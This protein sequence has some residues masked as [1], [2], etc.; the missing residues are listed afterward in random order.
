MLAAGDENF[1][2][3][4]YALYFAP[5][6]GSAWDR[7]G[8]AWLARDSALT[9]VPRRYGFHA[10]LKAPFRLAD[11]RCLAELTAQLDR[12]CATRTAFELPRMQVRRLGDFLAVVPAA[13]D[14]RVSA[15]AADC[16]Q[17]FDRFRAPLDSQE[18]AKRR[19][20]PLTARQEANLQL[21]G[22]PYVLEDF[23][24]H[25]SLTGPLDHA[26]RDAALR[27][28]R[29]AARAIARLGAEPFRFDAVTVFAEDGPGAALRAVH[30]SA[31]RRR[32]RLIYLVGPSGAGKDSLL[33]W[34]GERLPPG[35][36]V[37]FARRVITRPP[38]AGGEQHVPASV[39]EFASYVAEGAF[40]MH[41]KANGDRYGIERGIVD[42]LDAGLTVLVNGS[43]AYLPK[44]RIAFPALEVV[45]VTAAP[46]LRKARLAGRRRERPAAIRRR[47]A[48]ELP[49]P[50][51]AI[52]LVNDRALEIAGTKLLRY[53]LDRA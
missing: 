13:E 42:Q 25:F 53:L 15:I 23:R 50:A 12:F 5:A 1:V 18:L 17:R 48:R 40:A 35:A 44:A 51:A 26:S 7:F 52:E 16:V 8:R 3:V 30:R 27:T 47:L 49:V 4:R 31:L 9:S 6:P 14:A 10:T 11:G 39:R 37:C 28:G 41:W 38:Q 34:V 46:E 22:Y 45:H 33:S 36:P 19:R 2:T 21:W 29:A 24:F 32:G 43:R 20:V